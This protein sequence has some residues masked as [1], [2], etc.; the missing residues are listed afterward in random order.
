M[1]SEIQNK[2][3]FTQSSIGTFEIPNWDQPSLDKLKD[4]I[5]VIT[6]TITDSKRDFGDVDDVDP[7]AHFFRSCCWLG[8]KSAQGGKLN[9]CESRNE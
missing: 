7:I 6:S 9:Q 2:I 8:R 1:V 5:K 3:S 4:T